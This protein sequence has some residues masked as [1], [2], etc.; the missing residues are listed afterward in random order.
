V[1]FFWHLARCSSILRNNEVTPQHTGWILLIHPAFPLGTLRGNGRSGNMNISIIAC[2]MKH[3]FFQHKE[4]RT[5]DNI[6]Q[7]IQPEYSS[8]I[9]LN[10][11]QC[12]IIS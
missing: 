8:N 3:Y 10:S 7:N 6:M 9:E 1:L 2:T 12:M 4:E 11:S 5:L